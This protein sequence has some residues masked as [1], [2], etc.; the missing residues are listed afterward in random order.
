[1]IC[2]FRDGRGLAL[3]SGDLRLIAPLGFGPRILFL[4]LNGAENLLQ[5]FE[6]E[7]GAGSEGN[8]FFRGG[9]RLW[10]APEDPVRTYQPDNAPL[11]WKE[12]SPESIVL[13]APVEARTEIRKEIEIQSCGN[14]TFRL[15][16]RLYNEGL[17]SVRL[18]PW[19]LTVFRPG[20]VVVLPLP[21]K[22]EHP[23]DLLPSYSLIPWDYTDLSGP[24]WGFYTHFIGLDTRKIKT[25]QK[26][27]ISS[28]PPGWVGYWLE[29]LLFVKSA[30]IS[31]GAEY[32]DRGCAI[33]VFSNGKMAELETLGPLVD[34][35]SG[36]KVVHVE[37]WTVFENLPEPKKG[38]DWETQMVE[39]VE[40][41]MKQ[42]GE[43]SHDG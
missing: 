5:I 40:K 30:Q 4:G 37:E 22:G 19:G 36:E 39:T 24:E 7:E 25:P 18:A 11:T 23:R 32:P 17:W 6:E 13:R 29:G 16:H 12:L 38:T 14:R 9:H 33:E 27:G 20:G 3:N 31:A 34:L 15:V 21:P 28:V 41:W 35:G 43:M 26:L 10:H 42:R 1:M 8:Y 2:D